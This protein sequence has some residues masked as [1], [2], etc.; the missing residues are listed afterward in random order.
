MSNRYKW[1]ASIGTGFFFY[2]FLLVFLP[3]GV[4]NYNPNHEY[5][6][7]FLLEISYFMFATTILM[8]LNEFILK[9]RVVRKV[10]ISAVIG[11]SVWL[12]L[13]IGIGNYIL[14]NWLG[15]WH[16]L[17]LESGIYF[18]LNCSSVFLFPLVGIFFIYR[19][20]AL[21]N[22]I[23]EIELR[24]RTPPYYTRLIQF[25]GEGRS[26]Q[27]TIAADD[28]RYAQAQDNY[29]AL[30]Y[31]KNGKVHKEL[32]RSSLS[33][34]LVKA[35]SDDLV[36]CHR[37]YAVNINQVHSARQGNP[38]LLFLRDLEEPIRVSRSYTKAVRSS[39]TQS[40]LRA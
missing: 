11:W 15:N 6:A 16:D 10:S 34:L 20:Q 35:N 8:L 28:F 18:I 27:F 33:E 1:F 22:S 5:S 29:V 9:E 19:Y 39:L 36:R 23:Q 12:L 3:F 38:M 31:L 24:P 13:S 30:Y 14:Y 25:Q 7:A 40:T 32:I 37:S 2:L 4:D 17:S 21:K 26:D